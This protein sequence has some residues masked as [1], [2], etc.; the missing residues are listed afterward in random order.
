MNTS[1]DIRKEADDARDAMRDDRQSMDFYR[2]RLSCASGALHKAADLVERLEAERDEA[3]I[4][5]G[6][7][8]LAE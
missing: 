8:V 6:R 7:K 3:L 1:G 2:H 4:A 5:L